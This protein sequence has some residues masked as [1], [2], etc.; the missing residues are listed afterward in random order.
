M[1]VYASSFRFIQRV[2]LINFGINGWIGIGAY[3]SALLSMKLGFSFWLA[4]PLASVIGLGIAIAFAYPAERVQGLY[5]AVVTW[6]FAVVLQSVYTRFKEP[7]GGP[8]GLNQIPP[9]TLPWFP[10]VADS[11]VFWYYLGLALTLITLLAFFAFEKSRFGFTLNLIRASEDL[12]RSV[13]VNV[14]NYRILV[15]SM[16]CFFAA[17]AG[18]FYAHYMTAITP[19]VFDVQLAILIAIFLAIGGAEDFVG[20]VVGATLMTIASQ[21]LLPTGFFR[22]VFLG[23]LMVI[24]LL[25]LPGGLLGLPEM[26]RLKTRPV[27]NGGVRR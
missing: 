18:A 12:A 25:F 20:P 15:F 22:L 4:L 24:F 17:A 7:F 26:V 9:P 16:G 27:D 8:M 19:P 6:A 11:R 10:A 23:I 1:I 5:F 13:G 14:R 21:L 2:G 3:A